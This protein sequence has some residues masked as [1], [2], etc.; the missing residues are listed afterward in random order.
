MAARALRR[1]VGLA[2]LRLDRI[3]MALDSVRELVQLQA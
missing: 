3:H 2:E 1:R